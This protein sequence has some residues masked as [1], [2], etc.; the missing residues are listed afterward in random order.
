MK[1][2]ELK[3]AQL[4][5]INEHLAQATQQLQQLAVS[6]EQGKGVV[7]YLTNQKNKLTEELNPKEG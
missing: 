5:I 4:K 3:E 1:D 6:L 2:K 7:I